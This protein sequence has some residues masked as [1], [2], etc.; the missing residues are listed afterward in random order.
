MNRLA[1]VAA[2]AGIVSALTLAPVAAHAAT[3]T[4]APAASSAST[5][6][7]HSP[8]KTV[9]ASE[10]AFTSS[11]TYK[12]GKKLVVA[13]TGTP[14]ASINLDARGGLLFGSTTV[15]K[16]GTWRVVFPTGL[17]GPGQ[18]LMQITQKTTAGSSTVIEA[19]YTAAK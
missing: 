19:W 2:A 9:S 4:V 10:L 12:A 13:G 7:T 1:K 15:K 6:A 14:G 5:S 3:T 11:T 17:R 8:E 18:Y 16:N